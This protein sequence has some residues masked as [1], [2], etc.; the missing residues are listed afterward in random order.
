MNSILGREKGVKKSSDMESLGVIG[1][2]CSLSR[3][4]SFIGR[5]GRELNLN[6]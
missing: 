1:N 6:I 4:E 3:S 5:E 2:S